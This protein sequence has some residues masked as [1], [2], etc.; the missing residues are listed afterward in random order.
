MLLVQ[1]CVQVEADTLNCSPNFNL[2]RMWMHGMVLIASENMQTE[3]S[4]YTV[5]GKSEM[6]EHWNT[7]AMIQP[8]ISWI[9]LFLRSVKFFSIILKHNNTSH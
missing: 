4:N 1:Y 3:S 8:V 7:S 2:V 9:Q 6:C 5:S